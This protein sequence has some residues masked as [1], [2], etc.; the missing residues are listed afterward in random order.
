MDRPHFLLDS[1]K[2]C[3]STEN[4]EVYNTRSGVN[5]RMIADS[6]PSR[7]KVGDWAERDRKLKFLFNLS[8]FCFYPP[9]KIFLGTDIFNNLNPFITLWIKKRRKI[10]NLE[11]SIIIILSITL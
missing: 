7:R 1:V 4:R 9:H 8:S 6:W 10:S 5:E 11:S 2:E 3:H